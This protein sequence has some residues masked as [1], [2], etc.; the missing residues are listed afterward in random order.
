MFEENMNVNLN[1]YIGDSRVCNVKRK[2]EC[3][4]AWGMS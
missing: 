4:L 3:T 1:S 2:C